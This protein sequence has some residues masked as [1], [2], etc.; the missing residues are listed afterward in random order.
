MIEN[1]L[2]LNCL[3]G[4]IFII[5]GYLI[6]S[7]SPS[8]L[9]SKRLYNVDVRTLNSQNAGTTNFER[10]FGKK[11]SRVVFSLDVIKSVVAIV[12]CM[13]AQYVISHHIQINNNNLGISPIVAG[14][15]VILG[16]RFPIWHRFKGGK[17]VACC[18]GVLICIHPIFIFVTPILFSILRKGLN[19]VSTASM[20]TVSFLF[21]SVMVVLLAIPVVAPSDWKTL[22]FQGDYSTS[23]IS[24]LANN[25]ENNSWWRLLITGNYIYYFDINSYLSN[26]RSILTNYSITQETIYIWSEGLTCL[27]IPIFIILFHIPNI[28]KIIKGTERLYIEPNK[29]APKKE[30]VIVIS[31][32]TN[33]D[34]IKNEIN[35]PSDI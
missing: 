32:K 15:G 27:L 25:I 22:F 3:I 5:V 34:T 20:L 33:E 2:I 14:I 35:N 19:V 24:W 29:L 9:I 16:H 6:G 8:I 30:S 13:I 1:A 7:L 4:G 28:K 26:A 23:E 31:N 17:S 18:Y 12:I 10:S 21:I 11:Y